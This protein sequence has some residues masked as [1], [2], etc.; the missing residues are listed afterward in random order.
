MAESSNHE[1]YAKADLLH[2]FGTEVRYKPAAVPRRQAQVEP[3]RAGAFRVK[4][5]PPPPVPL[6]L[7]PGSY[8]SDST[9]TLVDDPFVA[10]MSHLH[11]RTEPTSAADYSATVPRAAPP[12]RRYG[13]I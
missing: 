1:N 8:E 3:S 6:E 2:L 4:R 5:I 9:L 12:N 13:R 7:A 10:P 11:R